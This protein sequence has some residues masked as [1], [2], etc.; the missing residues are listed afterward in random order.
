MP[1]IES[2]DLE[3]EV[4]VPYIVKNK[5]LMSPGIWNNYLYTKDAIA[6]AYERT[7]WNDKE[8]R[9]LFLDHKDRDSLEWVGEV[10]N[11]VISPDGEVRGDLVVVD[12]PTAMKLHYGAKFGISPKVEGKATD[13]NV[14]QEFLFRN[15]S[16]V[17]NPAVKTAYINNQEVKTDNINLDIASTQANESVQADIS[18]E[19]VENNDSSPRQEMTEEEMRDLFSGDFKEYIKDFKSTNPEAGFAEI[20]NSYR[21]V[22]KKMAED[23]EIKQMLSEIIGLLKTESETRQMLSEILGHV[24]PK[25]T[26]IENKAKEE[27]PKEEEKEKPTEMENKCKTPEEDMDKKKMMQENSE[28]SEKLKSTEAKVLELQQKLEVPENAVPQTQVENQE[29]PAQNHKNSDYG[30]LSFLRKEKGYE[31]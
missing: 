19:T 26:S 24:R 16:I 31:K 14:M 12:K 9:S 21:E 11:P 8:I 28:L 13:D 22:Q 29:V 18:K 2:L 1:D 7:D 17:I 15:M 25:E 3:K 30:M 6:G 23:N 5:V 20:V 27:E 10:I 4:K